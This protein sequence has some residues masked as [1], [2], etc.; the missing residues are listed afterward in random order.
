MGKVTD[1]KSPEIELHRK[2]KLH[3]LG[4][5]VASDLDLFSD[6]SNPELAISPKEFPSMSIDESYPDYVFGFVG[7]VQNELRVF[8]AP[9]AELKKGG[10]LKWDVLC[11]TSDNL[12]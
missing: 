12:V 7:T 4:S 5:T 9:A 8:Y 10:K 2:S 1:S 3:K 6:E 11:K